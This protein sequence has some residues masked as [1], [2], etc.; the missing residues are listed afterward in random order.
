MTI[1]PPPAAPDQALIDAAI[2]AAAVASVAYQLELERFRYV[3]ILGAQHGATIGQLAV[4]A[5]LACEQVATL[6]NQGEL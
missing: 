2:N 6:I 3:L 4:G 1:V 5:G